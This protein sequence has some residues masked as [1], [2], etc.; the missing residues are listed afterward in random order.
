GSFR[1]VATDGNRFMLGFRDWTGT[2][3]SEY[4]DDAKDSSSASVINL[5]DGSVTH[6]DAVLE[7]AASIAGT[8]HDDAGQPLSDT[9]VVAYQ[10]VGDSY[11]WATGGYADETG[12]YRL[13]GLGADTYRVEF[14]S[15][16]HAGEYWN[17]KPSLGEA[18]DVV[19]TTGEARTGVNAVLAEGASITGTVTGADSRPL[20]GAEI[21][22][23][24]ADE[25]WGGW[26]PVTYAS[27]DD[28]G[29][30]VATALA[31][32]TYR[33]KIEPQDSRHTDEYWND[34]VSLDEADDITVAAEADV[35]GIDAALSLG[36]SITGR[37]TL[38]G[39]GNLT[40]ITVTAF[41][42]DDETGWDWAADGE[43]ASDGTYLVAGLP[44]GSYTLGFSSSSATFAR[45][46]WKGRSTLYSADRIAVEASAA[47]TG[48]DVTLSRA[49]KVSGLVRSETGRL[50]DV[51][52]SA[53]TWEASTSSWTYADSTITNDDGSYALDGLPPGTYRV[54]FEDSEGHF[55]PEFY[56]D[57]PT[58]AE[59]TGVTVT[60]GA[61]TRLNDAVLARASSVSGTVTRRNGAP[62]NEIEVTA[63]RW[64]ALAKDWEAVAWDTT[65]TDGA[66]VLTGLARGTYRLR[67][68]DWERERYL[69][70]WWSGASDVASA[71]DVV[72]GSEQAVTGKDVVMVDGESEIG[73]TERPAVTG[74]ATVGQQLVAT[75][76]RWS[77]PGLDHS[78][79]WRADGEPITGTSGNTLTL[80]AD[81]VGKKIT[82][83]VTA[84]A[85]G[86][87]P[88]PAESLPT[89]PVRPQAPVG[90][91]VTSTSSAAATMSWSAVPGATGYRVLRRSDGGGV[92]TSIATGAATSATVTG[93][94]PSTAYEFAVVAIGGSV[95]SEPSSWAQAKTKPAPVLPALRA[96]SAPTVSGKAL[97][98][99]TLRAS[100]GRWSVAG[101][102]AS[103]QWMRAG[104]PIS[105]ATRPTYT[106]GSADVGRSVAVRVT[107]RKAGFASGAATSVATSAVKRKAGLRVTAKGA[108]EKATLTVRLT[109]AGLSRPGGK[110]VVTKRGKKVKTV[111]IRKG[112]AVVRL[113][114]K[115]GRHTYKVTYRATR[116]ATSATRTVTVRV[117]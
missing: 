96:T 59:A 2:Y 16:T 26:S 82:V 23:Y 29:H 91:T 99:T 71:S 93:L 116:T 27:T 6:A 62:L 10:K 115:K 58:L 81:L 76:G 101:A 92:V 60:A 108:R 13:S 52:V 54:G 79:A 67:F 109:L 106:L 100:A 113:T 17:D 24:E 22:V 107:V 85:T 95:V 20:E 32:G 74:T 103:Y 12:T 1:Y 64:D 39:G 68:E 111:K 4:W 55:A 8:V 37:V 53:Y 104:V 80:T 5:A 49:A 88:S 14:A 25:E 98:G 41:A 102:A 33:V 105:G 114:A 56:D 70:Q 21:T 15:E 46:Y 89:E 36:S 57:T 30:Y 117:R 94:A 73:N 18:D 84:S 87:E 47:L 78:Y 110:V 50:A 90:L 61:S 3:A 19:L 77:L 48:K 44:A 11:R 86:F 34:A 66:Y 31:A 38:A 65:G 75:R 63:H 35:S 45:Q 72:V 28:S 9:W 7:P 97:L 83:V 112:R 40:D 43:V 51:S 69:S 42:W